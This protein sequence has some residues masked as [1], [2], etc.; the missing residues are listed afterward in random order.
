ML[1][2]QEDAALINCTHMPQ[3][4]SVFGFKLPHQ[5]KQFIYPRYIVSRMGVFIDRAMS[6]AVSRR[7]VT[8]KARVR[9]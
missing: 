7:L 3:Q 2:G 9:S 1:M 8:T 6:Q 5:K 4:A